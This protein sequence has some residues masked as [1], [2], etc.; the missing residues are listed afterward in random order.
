MLLTDLI[1]TL[2]P[3][4]HAV[5]NRRRTCGHVSIS[6]NLTSSMAAGPDCVSSGVST[7][8]GLLALRRLLAWLMRQLDLEQQEEGADE[9]KRPG[10]AIHRMLLEQ[11][12]L[13]GRH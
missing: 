6:T 3:L 11:A 5:H 1:D 12:T 10:K 4:M 7:L 13:P 2:L 9:A 8:W